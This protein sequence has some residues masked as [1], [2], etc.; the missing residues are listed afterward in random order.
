M[1][2]LQSA[3]ARGL[4]SL[5][6]ALATLP[7]LDPASP[8]SLLWLRVLLGEPSRSTTAPNSQPA[9][10]LTLRLCD[11]TALE[12]LQWMLPADSIWPPLS[13]LLQAAAAGGSGAPSAAVAATARA[14]LRN[15]AVRGALL[16]HPEAMYHHLAAAA[17]PFTPGR[18]PGRS[19]LLA[20]LL[21]RA[22]PRAEPPAGGADATLALTER[23]LSVLT[24]ASCQLHWLYLRLLL[25]EEVI[26]SFFIS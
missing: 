2:F 8:G 24:P 26:S 3:I 9:A 14:V 20:M 12:A 17:E 10:H 7:A 19:L 4:V 13:G 21:G 1:I 11:A 5:P 22:A 18:L 6:H 25:D 16:R 15:D 23:V